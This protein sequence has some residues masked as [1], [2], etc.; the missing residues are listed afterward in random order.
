VAI[1]QPNAEFEDRFS[2]V[3]FRLAKSIRIGN[4]RLQGMFDLYN[5]FN[6]NAV[7]AESFAYGPAWLRPSGVLAGRLA[8]FGA[9]VEF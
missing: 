5:L 8:K 1:I 3:D 6:A 4:M 9:Q 2:Q 7:L